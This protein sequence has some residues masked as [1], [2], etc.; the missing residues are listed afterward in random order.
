MGP[1]NAYGALAKELGAGPEAARDVG[2]AMA[3]NPVALM[4]PCRRVLAAGGKVGGFRA[5]RLGGQD[6]H[7]RAGGRSRRGGTA[8][9]AIFR[10]LREARPPGSR[11]GKMKIEGGCLCGKVRYSADVEPTFVGVCHCRNCQKGTGSAFSVVVAPPTPALTVQGT[12]ETFTG[13]G[14]SGKATY[15]R[16]CP[17]CGSALIDEAEIMPNITMILAGTLDDASWVKPA[18]EIFCDSAQ[19]WVHLG[20]ERRRSSVYGGLGGSS[21]PPRIPRGSGISL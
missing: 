6:P 21:R 14:D 5:R 15:R 3:K 17:A 20:G 2:Q 9:T 19:P 4:I 12:L 10:V 13:R 11:R 7:A 8:G 18:S 1:H 16:F